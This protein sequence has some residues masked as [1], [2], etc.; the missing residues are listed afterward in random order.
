MSVQILKRRTSRG[1]LTRSA[2][3]QDRQTIAPQCRVWFGLIGVLSAALT[4]SSGMAQES[5][6]DQQPRIIVAAPLAIAAGLP[7]QLVLRGLNLTEVTEVKLMASDLKIEIASK[8]KAAVPQNYDAK[9]VGDSM[10]EVKFTLPGET[11]DGTV[12]FVA[13]S[14]AGSSAPYEV[15]VAR[16]DDLLVDKEPNDGFKTAQR[17][18]RGKTIIGTIHDPRNVDVFEIQAEAGQKLTATMR[19]AQVGSLLDPVLTLYDDA[20]QVVAASDDADGRDPRIDTI[21]RK[22]SSHFLV[23]QDAND[24][25]GP[26]FVYLLT[27][28]P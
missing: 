6:P 14:P 2:N 19:A 8:G 25:G 10:V 17:I 4:A 18:L 12:Q 26:Q 7:V 24:S 9:K 22:T 27:V 3:S 1:P 5:K 11:P 23:V 13:V 16:P 15:P 21:V 28:A 20:G